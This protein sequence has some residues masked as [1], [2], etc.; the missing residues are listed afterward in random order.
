MLQKLEDIRQERF[1]AYI[2][3]LKLRFPNKEIVN[4]TGYNS[5]IVS[6]YMRGKKF[7]SESFLRVFCEKFGAV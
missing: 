2:N 1:I 5:G 4:K 6:E 3:S 7:V